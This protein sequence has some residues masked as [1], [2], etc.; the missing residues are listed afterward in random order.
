MSEIVAR[1]TETLIL[2]RARR[3]AAAAISKQR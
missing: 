2:G 1:K 3:L